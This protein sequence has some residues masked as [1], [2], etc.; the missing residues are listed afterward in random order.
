[1]TSLPK[2][3]LFKYLRFDKTQPF[4]T[5][6]A[7]LAFLGVSIGLMVLIVA[8]AIMNGFD[9][10]FERKLFTMNY[11]ISVMSAF[12][13]EINDE[14]TAEL[15]AKFP[16]LKFSPYIS[17]QVIYRGANTLEGGL[18]FGV[19]SADE[20]QINSVVKEAL[21]DKELDGYEILIGSGIK[22]EFGLKQNDK[23]T[24]IFTK[25]DPGGFSLIPKMKRFDVAAGFSSG[26][27]A[28]D[29]TYS[30]TSVQALRKI[31]DYP[32][33][34]YDGIHV[35]SPK[36]FDDLARVQE[37]LPMGLKA[38]GWWQQNGNFFSA[39]ALEKRALFIVLMLI[40]L[41]A[42]LN[43]IS[44]LLMTVMNRRQE[45]A[46]L[47]ALGASKNEIKQSFFYQGLVIGGSGIVFGLVLGFVGMWLLG[48]FNIINLPADVYGTSKLP[49]ELSLLD[50]AMIVAGA[51]LIVAVS[52]YYPAKKATQ[53]DVLQT[54]RNE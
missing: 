41:V 4:I 18:L 35:Y 10:E 9:K 36:P 14:L 25:A 19:N 43:I 29:K 21:K 26:L 30:Y 1:M 48:N 7:M 34:V 8:M 15:K 3:L 11:P 31:L 2:Y 53:I 17:T 6:S 23:L 45:I 47:L 46:L 22:S 5:L 20:K 33:G 50:F 27:I 24:L 38:I 49:M 51:V 54:L 13:G 42:S 32:E 40:I 12:K 37:A 39:L 16:E 44:S 28:Y 52:S